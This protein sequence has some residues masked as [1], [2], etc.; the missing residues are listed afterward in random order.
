MYCESCKKNLTEK[1]IKQKNKTCSHK[2]RD[3]IHSKRMRGK[4]HPLYGKHLSKKWKENISKATKGKNKGARFSPKTEFK[5][6][7]QKNI[8]A[9]SF[10]KGEGN[11]SWKGGILRSERQRIMKTD[12][13]KKWR[14]GVFKRD[15]YVCQICGKR[16]NKLQAD[17]I[18]RFSD[19]PEL[20]FKLD[21]GR[22]L[23]VSC[24]ILTPNYGNKNLCQKYQII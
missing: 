15:N 5:K 6:G 2:C 21:N 23:C 17:H 9:Y 10:P 7:D 11:P 20:R 22:T 16:G 19:Y 4:N 24:H 18:K 8:K 13:Y 12:E 14:N 1:Q 3:M